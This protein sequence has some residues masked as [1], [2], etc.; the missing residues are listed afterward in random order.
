[1]TFSVIPTLPYLTTNH[2]PQT[3]SSIL[4]R[5]HPIT[6]GPF[7]QPLPTP[8]FLYGTSQS[9]RPRPPARDR[10]QPSSQHG[11]RGGTDRGEDAH[12]LINM[13]QRETSVRRQGE[14]VGRQKARN[15]CDMASRRGHAGDLCG[16]V[17]VCMGQDGGED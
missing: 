1:M 6:H 16:R 4:T 7:P 5:G 10:Q 12:K 8:S 11:G 14:G 9:A 15:V 3:R 2:L 13:R 17:G